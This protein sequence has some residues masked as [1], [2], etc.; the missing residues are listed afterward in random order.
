MVKTIV[1]YGNAQRGTFFV[2]E[3]PEV[4]TR[5]YSGTHY[6]HSPNIDGYSPHNLTRDDE[7]DENK[8]SPKVPEVDQWDV[9]V[10]AEYN[11]ETA[12]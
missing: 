3:A 11:L 5:H 8:P 9:K 6:D 2:V 4:E 7:D 12:E 10:A 1:E